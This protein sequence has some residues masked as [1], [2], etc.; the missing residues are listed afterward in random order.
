MYNIMYFVIAA[1]SIHILII[2][3]KYIYSSDSNDSGGNG[4]QYSKFVG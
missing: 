3:N 1:L 4:Q 2:S